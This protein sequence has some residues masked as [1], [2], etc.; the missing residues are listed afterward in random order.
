MMNDEYKADKLCIHHSSLRTHHLI[1]KLLRELVFPVVA[2]VFAFIVGGII[3]WL[4]GDN[5]I[6]AGRHRLHAFLRYAD[7]L[8][9]A[10]R[11]GRVPLRTFEYR[12]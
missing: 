5:P 7:H 6:Q 10:G 4:V 11:R 1:M 3:V 8:H 9:G 12:R 2:V